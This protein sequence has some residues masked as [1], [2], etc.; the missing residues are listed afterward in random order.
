MIPKFNAERLA[1]WRCQMLQRGV[2]VEPIGP[3]GPFNDG[4]TGYWC[5][6]SNSNR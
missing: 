1:N 2:A 5:G 6:Q 3:F 4:E